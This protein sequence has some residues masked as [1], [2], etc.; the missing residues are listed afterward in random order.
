MSSGRAIGQW[1]QR[2]S[3]RALDLPAINWRASRA[4]PL[5]AVTLTP[6]GPSTNEPRSGR[7]R[8]STDPGSGRK[9]GQGGDGSAGA[10]HWLGDRT[11]LASRCTQDQDGFQPDWFCGLA[12]V[13]GFASHPGS[14]HAARAR[15]GP[16][17]PGVACA[18]GSFL[19]S[20][21]SPA[22]SSRIPEATRVFEVAG[23]AGARLPN[24]QR[25]ARGS[26]L[27]ATS[28]A[29]AEDA[30]RHERAA[31]TRPGRPSC[32]SASAGADQERRCD[33]ARRSPSFSPARPPPSGRHGRYWH[34]AVDGWRGG[35]RGHGRHSRR[36]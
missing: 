31:T 5:P 7:R 11:C 30:S 29:V 19:I 13:N 36:I 14:G 12:V 23:P 21:L 10:H 3:G 1:P 2:A 34:P 17:R 33:R 25:A 35:H 16:R 27:S 24:E 18:K 22:R 32:R 26:L 4:I 6:A 8:A 28:P 9:R 20:S 15:T